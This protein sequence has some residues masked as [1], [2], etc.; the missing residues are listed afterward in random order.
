M[1]TF[2]FE[3]NLASFCPRSKQHASLMFHAGAH[4]PSIRFTSDDLCIRPSRVTPQAITC[5][6]DMTTIHH[7][8]EAACPPERVW[9]VLSDLEAVQHYNP[10]VRAAAVRGERRFGVGA[11]WAGSSTR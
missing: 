9:A 2:T 3:G 1:P 8:I 6:A 10:T 11:E 7:D 5:G 4:A